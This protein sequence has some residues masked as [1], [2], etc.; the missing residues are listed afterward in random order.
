MKLSSKHWHSVNT[1][2]SKIYI[3]ILTIL[4]IPSTLWS[5]IGDHFTH[6]DPDEAVGTAAQFQALE[7]EFT[8][9]VCAP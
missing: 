7:G 9:H 6:A 8:G 5:H 2:L 1:Y 3:S 4:F